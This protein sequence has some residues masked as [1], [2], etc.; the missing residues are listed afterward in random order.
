MS[1]LLIVL[2]S[3]VAVAAAIRSTWS[4]SACRCSPRSH[5]S[6][7]AAATIG[8][9]DGNV[10]RAG[11]R[12]RRGHAGA[13]YGVVGVRGGPLD[14]SAT[15]ALGLSAVL[16]AVS[17]ASDLKLGGFRLP[18]HTRQVNEAWL[19]EFRSWVYGSGFGCRSASGWPY[20]T[21]SA[22]YLMIAM[23]AL[24][25]SPVVAFAV[26]TGVSRLRARAGGVRRPPRHHPRAG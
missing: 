13:G 21:T 22:V 20:V 18:S 15:D 5:R 26:A 24:T 1:A 7:S 12:P 11:G 25:G 6:Q 23:S 2:T 17:I 4:P 10:V 14:L 9:T 16:A 8:T 3:F 19:D